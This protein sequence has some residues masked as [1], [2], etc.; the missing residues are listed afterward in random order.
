MEFI[1]FY[2]WSLST[3]SYI[4]QISNIQHI[5]FML[6]LLSKRCNEILTFSGW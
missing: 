3:F 6:L 4:P 1:I 2:L 5:N